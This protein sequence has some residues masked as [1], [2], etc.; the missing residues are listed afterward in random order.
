[1]LVSEQDLE[2]ASTQSGPLPVELCHA[3]AISRYIGLKDRLQETLTAPHR[4]QKLAAAKALMCLGDKDSIKLLNDLSSQ[5]QDKIAAAIFKLASV[6]LE[7]SSSLK[8]LLSRDDRTLL[9]LLPSLYNSYLPLDENDLEILIITL[10]KYLSKSGYTKSIR[11]SFW[12][13][14]VGLLIEALANPHK[15]AGNILNSRMDLTEDIKDIL[16]KLTHIY[17]RQDDFSE[18]INQISNILSIADK[19]QIP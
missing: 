5:E 7:G 18:E 3:A 4:L 10:N 1:M 14:D 6:R 16:S 9:E 11:Q 19:R 15:R 2:Q 12:E 13:N 17:F 8:N